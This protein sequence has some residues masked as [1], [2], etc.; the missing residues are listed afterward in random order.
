MLL[1][2][3]VVKKCM[4]L[5]A[6]IFYH[7][8]HFLLFPPK[9]ERN[10]FYI[11]AASFLWNVDFW[12]CVSGSMNVVKLVHALFPSILHQTLSLL[13]PFPSFPNPNI[14]FICKHFFP[15][16]KTFCFY[17]TKLNW[18]QRTKKGATTFC[19]GIWWQRYSRFKEGSSFLPVAHLHRI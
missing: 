16:G 2:N 15:G 4:C 18:L 19:K 3:N 11:L 7:S 10:I 5:L 8:F 6:G 9:I 14:T 13:S 1:C 17:R 12:N